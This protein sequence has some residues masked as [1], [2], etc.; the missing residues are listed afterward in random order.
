MPPQLSSVAILEPPASIAALAG[1]MNEDD[2]WTGPHC[3]R[4]RDV[5]NAI[6]RGLGFDA[7]RRDRLSLG[8]ELHDIGKLWIPD[9]IVDKPGPLDA[10][11]QNVMRDHPELGHRILRT[12]GLDDVAGWVLHHHER[13]DGSGYPYGLKG[14][15]IPLEAR[16]IFVADAFD[17]MTADRPYAAARQP[18]DAMDELEE[19]AGTQFDHQCVSVLSAAMHRF[20]AGGD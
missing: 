19:H 1:A 6:A 8:A 18:A 20:E 13:V 4:V 3:E 7:R 5:C 15:N 11:E 12:A 10:W 9:A 14:E 16:I 2:R 17:A